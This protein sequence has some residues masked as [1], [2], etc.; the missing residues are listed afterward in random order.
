MTFGYNSEGAILFK[1]IFSFIRNYLSLSYYFNNVPDL[2]QSV[3]KTLRNNNFLF[4]NTDIS[5]AMVAF[6]EN[7]GRVSSSSYKLILGKSVGQDEFI[8]IL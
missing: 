2:I 4:S 3:F 1:K 6:A 5:S 8:T 7:L